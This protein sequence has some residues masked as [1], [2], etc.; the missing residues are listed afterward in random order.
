[1]RLQVESSFWCTHRCGFCSPIS[2][3]VLASHTPPPLPSV[4]GELQNIHYNTCYLLLVRNVFR[5]IIYSIH[6]E[7]GGILYHHSLT[8]FFYHRNE[9]IKQHFFFRIF[10][11][12][13]KNLHSG[14]QAGAA[15]PQP[16][17]SAQSRRAEDHGR[18]STCRYFW[19]VFNACLITLLLVILCRQ[20]TFFF[21]QVSFNL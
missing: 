17:L 12:Y 4:S 3:S 14:V 10:F 21:N 9:R 20:L 6:G 1:M 11:R 7:F 13:A 2:L 19:T 18:V 5:K 8:F 16:P 15:L